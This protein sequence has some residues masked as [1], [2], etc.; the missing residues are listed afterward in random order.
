MSCGITI[1]EIHQMKSV[2]KQAGKLVAKTDNP[3]FGFKRKREILAQ[4][5]VKCEEIG[6]CLL[7]GSGG[8]ICFAH[9]EK[10]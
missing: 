9:L 10:P 7:S 1:Q 5:C 2:L 3:L 8:R 4:K 6:V